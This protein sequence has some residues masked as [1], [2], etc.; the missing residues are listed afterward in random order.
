[1]L[2]RILTGLFYAGVFFALGAWSG[3]HL[4][5]IW[6]AVENGASAIERR[7][8]GDPGTPSAPPVAKDKTTAT[9]TPVPEQPAVAESAELDNDDASPSAAASAAAD[10]EQEDPAGSH[11]DVAA[12]PAPEPDAGLDKARR[13]FAQGDIQGAI[14]A[15]KA[16]LVLNPGDAQAHGEL[17]NVYFNGGQTA[18]AADAFYAAALLLMADG[19][20]ETARALEPA[21]RTG[22]PALAA[23]L[24]RRLE[25]ETA[26]PDV[27]TG[28][29]T[30]S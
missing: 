22:A 18:E 24:L 20:T 15:Y 5:P 13:A 2:A 11:D 6:T 14:T 12:T 19:R 25:I 28:R 9:A 1:M 10:V 17:G 26:A 23:D 27:A 29:E 3:G 21:I 4:E 16:H 30:D 8:V 7:L